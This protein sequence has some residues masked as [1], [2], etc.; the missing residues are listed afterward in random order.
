MGRSTVD[1][2]AYPGRLACGIEAV[3]IANRL[4]YLERTRDYRRDLRRVEFGDERDERTRRFL[5]A[6]SPLAAAEAIAAALLIFPGANDPRVDYR[7]SLQMVERLAG[8]GHGAWS[9]LAADGGHGL[10]GAA[11]RRVQ[12][13]L[14]VSFLKRHVL[15]RPRP[16][17]EH[18]AATPP[19]PHR[20]GARLRAGLAGAALRRSGRA[21]PPPRDRL[22]GDHLRP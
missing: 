13:Q 17:A 15:G 14:T 11:N 3:G 10:R 1:S 22:D 4:T 8:C 6:I 16:A 5:A 12:R 9:A 7:E 2:A 18:L 20:D 19:H 21:R